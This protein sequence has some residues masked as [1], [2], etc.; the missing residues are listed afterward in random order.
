M[1]KFIIITDSCSDLEVNMRRELGVEYIKMPISYD[2]KQGYCS[3]DWEELSAKNFYDMLRS[4][5][6]F[7]TAQINAEM[8]KDAYE[9]HLKNGYDILS[10]TC[11]SAL[12][13]SINSSKIA[14]NELSK[15][16]PERKILCVDSLRGSL[17]QGLI[18][19]Y[20]A[21][22]Q[23]EGKSM[24][25]IESWIE[26]NKLKINQVG[27][28]DDL[29]YLKRAGRVTGTAAVMSSILHIKPIIIADEKGNNAS[30]AKVFGRKNSI[31]KCIELIEKTVENPQEQIFFICHAD[32]LV[33]AEEMKQAL[34]EK[35]KCKDVYINW[36]GPAIGATVG[37]GMFGIYYLGKSTAA[38]ANQQ[39]A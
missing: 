24:Q 25:Q 30:I 20:A 26:D 18:V 36:V 17:G 11:S 5:T 4:G 39:V 16:Y 14:C 10:I 31:K 15:K 6:V 8:Y 22:M 13:G 2:D 21:K 27:S 38:N 3:L 32:C 19:Y 7:K 23:K 1:S 12:S 35:F 29:K 9:P 33:E 34:I 37:P 28:V